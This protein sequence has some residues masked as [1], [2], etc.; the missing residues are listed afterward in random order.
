MTEQDAAVSAG[1]TTK[2]PSVSRNHRMNQENIRP[3]DSQSKKPQVAK[4]G[5]F[6]NVEKPMAV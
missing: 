6:V 4:K 5:P 1:P 2:P 3:E